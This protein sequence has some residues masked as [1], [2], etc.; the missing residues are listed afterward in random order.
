MSHAAEA[1]A[2]DVRAEDVIGQ[3][4]RRATR[5]REV[6]DEGAAEVAAGSGVRLHTDR[7]RDG[8]ARAQPPASAARNATASPAA[9]GASGSRVI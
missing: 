5:V 8:A 7:V 9:S 4:Q 3:G 1:R 6:D 2:A